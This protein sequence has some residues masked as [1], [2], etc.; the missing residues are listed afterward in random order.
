VS[1]AE[2]A[3]RIFQEKKA[4]YGESWAELSLP[5]FVDLLY[6]KAQRIRTLLLK[7]ESATGEAPLYDWLALANYAGLALLKLR[8][9]QAPIEEALSTLYLEA[10]RLLA[11][12]NADYGDAWQHMRP[13]AFIEFILM[14]LSRLRQMDQE[15]AQHAP[16]IQDNL[17]DI[18]NYALLYLSRYG[19]AS[20]AS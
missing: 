4:Q 20:F 14:K 17:F 11:R 8:H 6:I 7:G 10:Q 18:L 19:N 1:W 12:K 16:S 15:V 2:Q 9:V 13:L 3:Q 5:S